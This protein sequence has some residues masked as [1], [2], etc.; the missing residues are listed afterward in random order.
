VLEALGLGGRRLAVRIV[1]PGGDLF[2]ED[3]DLAGFL[4]RARAQPIGVAVS[5]CTAW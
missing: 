3:V 4:E 1:E 2:V 5:G